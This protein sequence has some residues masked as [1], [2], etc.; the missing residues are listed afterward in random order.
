MHTLHCPPP[1][2]ETLSRMSSGIFGSS[3]Q[4]HNMVKMITRGSECSG[5]RRENKPFP[6]DI[7][8]GSL[9]RVSPETSSESE[10]R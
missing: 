5:S 7:G 9:D 6:G 3:L 8:V 2:C 10:L 1:R 4:K